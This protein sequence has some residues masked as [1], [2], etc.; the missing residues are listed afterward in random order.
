MVAD[1]GSFFKFE[2]AGGELHGLLHFLDHL[3]GFFLAEF[4][5]VDGVISVQVGDFSAGFAPAFAL[6]RFFE[7]ADAR[8][9]F[10]LDLLG[11]YAVVDVPLLLIAAA[12]PRGS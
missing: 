1:F 9:D 10:A 7:F 3:P 6:R 8:V 5:V 12:F 11:G 2:F 4:G